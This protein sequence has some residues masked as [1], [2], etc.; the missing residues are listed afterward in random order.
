MTPMMLYDGRREGG[1]LPTHTRTLTPASFDAPPS[2]GRKRQLALGG[3][4]RRIMVR[5]MDARV[6][7]LFN[8]IAT[9]RTTSVVPLSLF[10]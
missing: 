6:H 10:E 4:A 2:S 5:R 1:G 7:R 8:D 3:D 9:V